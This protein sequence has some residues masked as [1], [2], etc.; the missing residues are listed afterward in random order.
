[1]TFDPQQFP[2]YQMARGLCGKAIKRV[3]YRSFGAWN[4]SPEVAHWAEYAIDL[5][6]DDGETV[7][8][9]ADDSYLQ[10]WPGPFARA[11]GQQLAAHFISGSG[12]DYYEDVTADP[13]WQA[14]LGRSID[15]VVFY[16][17]IG[18]T[19]LE[20]G[21]GTAGRTWIAAVDERSWEPL[22]LELNGASLSIIFDPKI[23]RLLFD[24]KDEDLFGYEFCGRAEPN[25]YEP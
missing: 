21:F 10:I 2:G 5:E 19:I 14:R 20:L 13:H 9:A 3:F 11:E 25:F 15:R 12:S 16:R 4:D 1:M 7:T 6:L 22:K 18:P 24:P 8:I 23:G 17:C